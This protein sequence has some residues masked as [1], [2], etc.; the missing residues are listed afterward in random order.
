M[1]NAADVS[2]MMWYGLTFAMSVITV[3][4]GVIWKFMRD[5]QAKHAQELRMKASSDAL[6][7][8]R[9]N[10]RH[11]MEAIKTHFNDRLERQY[12]E[13]QERLRDLADR[14]EKEIEWIKREIDEIKHTMTN[15]QA[16]TRTSFETLRKEQSEGVDKVLTRMNELLS[17]I[18]K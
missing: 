5:E 6:R 18:K 10:H 16:E 1:N 11:D 13:N 8:M 3:L 12:K 7:E 9:D 17:S 15:F 2:P 4:L 14:Q